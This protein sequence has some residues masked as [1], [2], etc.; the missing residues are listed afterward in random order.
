MPSPVPVGT[1]EPIVPDLTFTGTCE[2][3]LTRAV[4]PFRSAEDR[5]LPGGRIDDLGMGVVLSGSRPGRAEVLD[6]GGGDV[7]IVDLSGPIVI[8]GWVFPAAHR[9]LLALL[10][11]GD[12]TSRKR[13]RRLMFP[14]AL[15]LLDEA[16]FHPLTRPLYLRVGFRDICRD[17][18]LHE[19]TGVRF[20]LPDG[21]VGRA[22]LDYDDST[23]V[24]ASGRT[25]SDPA[26]EES[27]RDGFPG[28]ELSVRLTAGGRGSREIHLAGP[29]PRSLEELRSELRKVRRGFMHL[30]ARFEPDR[31]AAVRDAVGAFGERDSLARLGAGT[32]VQPSPPSNDGDARA[33]AALGSGLVH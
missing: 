29:A 32:R 3:T 11:E 28:R 8:F 10:A 14:M 26:L 16:G 15:R 19:G 12:A 5:A 25:R 17:L 2:V 30:L 24:V 33:L 18:D 27:L 20:V 31:Y 6:L 7:R 21:G 22:H 9:G 13:A 4:V 23:V 1:Q